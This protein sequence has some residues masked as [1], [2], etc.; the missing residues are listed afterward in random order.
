MRKFI[1]VIILLAVALGLLAVYGPG[2]Y[3][4][5]LFRRTI[6]QFIT[7]AKAG[8]TAAWSALIDS[9]QQ[10][11]TTPQ[12]QRLPADY[13]QHIASLKL[14]SYERSAPDTIW[15][16]ITCRLTEDSG[17][18]IYQGK[19]RWRWQNGR[20]EWDFTGSFAAPFS[21]SEEPDWVELSDMLRLAEA[22]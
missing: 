17:S 21:T 12:L 9:G 3:Q 11:R 20:W 8:D 4:G 18:G 14:T 7:S 5:L 15:A 2:A 22:F 16:I 1:P 13:Q 6:G 10:Q 19:L